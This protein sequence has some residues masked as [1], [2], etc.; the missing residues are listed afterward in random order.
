MSMMQWIQISWS[1]WFEQSWIKTYLTD[2]WLTNGDQIAC[3]KNLGKAFARCE[4]CKAIFPNWDACMTAAESRKRGFV[5]CRCGGMRLSPAR[6]PAWESVW[7]FCVRGWAVRHLLM[8]KRVWDPRI[9]VL[10]HDM[11]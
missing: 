8:K 7:W 1:L 4:K 11:D 5:G 6:I 9:T 2:G 3:P 10:V